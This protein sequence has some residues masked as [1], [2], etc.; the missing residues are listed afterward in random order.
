MIFFLYIIQEEFGV[1]VDIQDNVDE[2]NEAIDKFRQGETQFE[3]EFLEVAEDHPQVVSR[4]LR[5]DI[6]IPID[7]VITDDNID[8]ARFIDDLCWTTKNE[9]K[10]KMRDGTY[11]EYPPEKI[12]T[13]A[14]HGSQDGRVMV[15]RPETTS[16]LDDVVLL[17]ETCVWYDINNDGVEER[18]IVT[19][20]DSSPSDILRF[21]EMPYDHGQWPY[22]L[23]KRE[24]NDP[25]VYSSR[26][27]CALDED[28]QIGI[29]TELNQ[30]VNNGTIVNN[31]IVVVKKNAVQNVR[32]NRYIPGNVVEVNNSTAD[33]DIR[34]SANISQ[35]AKLQI[36]QFLKGWANQRIVT[37]SAIMSDPTNLP[38][39]GQGGKKT[40]AE[41]SATSMITGRATALDLAIF[42][43][44]M[45]R[46]YY[47]IDALYEQFGSDSEF[48]FIT[49]GKKVSTSRRQIQGR[50]NMTPNGRLDNTNPAA[51][52]AKA[53]TIQTMYANDPYINQYEL[54]RYVMQ[55]IDITLADKLLKT[56]EQ[57]Q[58][59]AQRGAVQADQAKR[60][61]VAESAQVKRLFD[62]LDLEKEF[63]SS[64]IQGKPHS[65]ED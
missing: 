49:G 13:W 50:Y 60:Q 12:D 18:C 59:E 36:A 65:K 47:Q 61:A 2:I 52:A 64:K 44:Q 27:I 25:G 23:V 63:V 42:Q 15:K 53:V 16:E 9:I 56:A 54:R 7:T 29:S 55:E 39:S 10:A 34:Q 3:L 45:A 31:P 6:I 4:S 20:A 37:S 8:A 28:M 19:W 32:N 24:W 35:G 22:T 30:T 11:I 43:W 1:D 14:G 57:L 48:E 5:E 26:G 46:V 58:Q 21:I 62:S 40:K 41:I 17:H 38:G 33:Y 51:R